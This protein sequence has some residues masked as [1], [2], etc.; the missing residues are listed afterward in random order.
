MLRKQLFLVLLALALGW[1][2]VLQAAHA[3]THVGEI[4]PGDIVSELETME[5]AA[6]EGVTPPVTEEADGE[7]DNDRL[8]L[9]CLALTGF[10]VIFSILAIVFSSR[11][12]RQAR[13]YRKSQPLFFN[14]YTPYSTRGPPAQAWRA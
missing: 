14:S 7:A 4:T 10:S 8:C 2:P 3:L 9:D 1:V 11:T 6:V 13:L 5:D 12:R